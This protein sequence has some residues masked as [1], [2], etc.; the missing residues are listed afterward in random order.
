MT[1]NCWC[2]VPSSP[3]APGRGWLLGDKALAFRVFRLKYNWYFKME[4][5]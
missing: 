2:N 1:F 5:P 3:P 4:V